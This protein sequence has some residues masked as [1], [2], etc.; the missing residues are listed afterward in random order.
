M[1]DEFNVIL[2]CHLEKKSRFGPLKKWKPY[3]FVLR[4]N[5]IRQYTKNDKRVNLFIIQDSNFNAHVVYFKDDE[6]G[7]GRVFK[8]CSKQREILLRAKTTV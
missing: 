8:V 6:E 7:Q 3:R 1:A 2:D 5:D 4:K